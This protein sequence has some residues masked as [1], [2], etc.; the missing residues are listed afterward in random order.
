MLDKTAKVTRKLTL[1]QFWRLRIELLKEIHY[2]NS[3]EDKVDG[4][5][6][7]NHEGEVEGEMVVH[8]EDVVGQSKSILHLIFL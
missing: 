2:K 5:E 7:V 6:V 1:H 3:L 4:F 8:H